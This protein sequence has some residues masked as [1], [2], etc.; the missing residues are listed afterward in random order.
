MIVKIHQ[1]LD[2]TLLPELTADEVTPVQIKTFGHFSI[3]VNGKAILDEKWQGGKTML[4]LK[5]IIVL[6]GTKVSVDKIQDLLWPDSEGDRAEASF[7]M[8]LSRLRKMVLT[9]N[10]VPIPWI[11]VKNRLVSLVPTLCR[12]DCLQFKDHLSSGLKDFNCQKPL[13]QALAMYDADFLSN[14]TSEGWINGFRRELKRDYVK[15]VVHL[16]D[17]Y[18]KT[19]EPQKSIPHLDA[20]LE[21]D[22]VNEELYGRLMR[23]YLETGYP[24]MAIRTSPRAKKVLEEEVGIPP[25]PVLCELVSRSRK[26]KART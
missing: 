23:C 1:L 5:A 11:S 21:V 15:G 9:E 24:A 2:P 16:T 4:L 3:A 14:E 6:G 19:G 12:V 22:P 10:S 7:K 20:A 17:I 25:G 8:T 13:E 18:R 26:T